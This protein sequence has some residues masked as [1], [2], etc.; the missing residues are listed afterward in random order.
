MA[1]NSR[2]N[3]RILQR[4][5]AIE[6]SLEQIGAKVDESLLLAYMPTAEDPAVKQPAAKKPAAKKKAA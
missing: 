6:E 2:I 4:L 3:A 1:S 5:T